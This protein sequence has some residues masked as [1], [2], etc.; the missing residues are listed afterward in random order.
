MDNVTDTAHPAWRVMKF[1]QPSTGRLGAASFAVVDAVVS[2]GL[3]GCGSAVPSSVDH[4]ASGRS[5]PSATAGSG[6][7]SLTP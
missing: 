6:S 1:R 7:T 4:P 5:T 3:V 2:V